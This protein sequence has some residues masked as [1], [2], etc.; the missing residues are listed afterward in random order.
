[1]RATEVHAGAGVRQAEIGLAEVGARGHAT[2]VADEVVEGR[3][4]V[5][6]EVP[7]ICTRA[8]AYLSWL[9]GPQ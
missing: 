7:A 1:M 8:G 3:L 5:M 6:I 4:E 9:Q 2:R